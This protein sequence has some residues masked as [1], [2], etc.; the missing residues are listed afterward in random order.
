MR[1][2]THLEYNNTVRDLLGDTTS[3]ANALPADE[4]GNGFGN[5]AEALSVS[6]LLVEQWGTVAARVAER[7]TQSAALARL[8]SCATGVTAATEAAC[9][10]TIMQNLL[11]RAYRRPVLPAEVDAYQ[12]LFTTVRANATF[13]VGVAAMLETMLQSA[14]F[15][16]RPELG[17]P[18]PA[19]PEVRRLTGAEVA[20]R[21]SYLLWAT[22]P[23]DALRAA[24]AAGELATK[25]AVLMH[26]KRMLDDPRARAVVR[27]FFENLLPTSG[28]ASLE[29]DKAAFP[30]YS[31][32]IGSLMREETGRFLEYEVFDGP[33]T[34]TSA[35]TASYTFVNAPL[36]AY[37]G[38]S[39]VKG[40]AF[41][42][43]AV[44]PR[45]LGVLSLGGVMA[46]TTTS[47]HTNPVT[48]GSFIVHKL[49]C[50][51]VPPPPQ[52]LLD[53]VK[54]PDPYSAP[55]ARERFGKHS[56]DPICAGCHRMMDPLGLALENFDPV[57]L[58]RTTENGVPIDASGSVPG[59]VGAV[60]G[61]V[62]LAQKLAQSED[63]QNCFANHV[64]EYAYGVTLTP[65]DAC[66]Q[67]AAQTS[68]KASRGNVRQLLLDLTQTDAFLYLA[69]R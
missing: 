15:L 45:R 64:V 1:R 62:E 38:M 13:A 36:A 56:Q 40:D 61:P 18:D 26:A 29:R 9:A 69:T 55:T 59:V 20:T 25:E 67:A 58:Y 32:T 34:W 24:A 22:V 43:V 4:A 65:E 30:T 46:G 54:P 8:A 6:S 21:L 49:M 57:G 31:A 11:P 63:V 39:G 50:R 10:R 68:F 37:Y 3:P 2:L 19:R 16:Y 66:L 51:P 48:R 41:Q 17:A 44:D 53:Q 23:D 47:N 35:L 5:D 28:L 52:A 27:Y 60:R 12:A 42:K 14:H 33:G 7:A